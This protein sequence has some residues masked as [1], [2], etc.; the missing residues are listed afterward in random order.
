MPNCSWSSCKRSFYL[1]VI[2]LVFPFLGNLINKKNKQTYFKSNSSQYLCLQN[3]PRLLFYTIFHWMMILESCPDCDQLVKALFE[4][5]Y[6]NNAFF[7]WDEM[8]HFWSD[9]LMRERMMSPHKVRKW[10]NENKY[11]IQQAY[12][13]S[14]LTRG[15]SF[16]SPLK[17][18]DCTQSRN[19]RNS[20]TWTFQSRIQT[21]N[22]PV[23]SPTLYR[24]LYR[25]SYRGSYE[26]MNHWI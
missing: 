8:K 19:Y 9:M 7:N 17:D 24:P 25:L 16:M 5:T 2:D 21:C 1:F 4:Q 20:L 11:L 15:L 14:W 22:L 10:N 23:T 13:V 12:T 26:R 3:V 18:K 6:K